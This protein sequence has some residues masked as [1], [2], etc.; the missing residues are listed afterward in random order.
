MQFQATRNSSIATGVWTFFVSVLY[1]DW[2][3]AFAGVPG[4]LLTLTW[5][6]AFF[7]P[8]GVFVTGPDYL[9]ASKPGYDWSLEFRKTLPRMGWLCLSWVACIFIGVLASSYLQN[10]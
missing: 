1:F 4:F 3:P 6:A 10:P 9:A 2:Q 8:V 5:L 7:I